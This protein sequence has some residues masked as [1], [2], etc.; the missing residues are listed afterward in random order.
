MSDTP[1]APVDPIIAAQ[2]RILER[3]EDLALEIGEECSAA[4]DTLGGYFALQVWGL[5]VFGLSAK[6]AEAAQL[7]GAKAPEVDE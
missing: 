3:F 2:V 6:D 5:L 1:R 7:Y 4:G